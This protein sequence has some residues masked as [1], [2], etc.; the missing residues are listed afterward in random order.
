MAQAPSILF[1]ARLVL[2]KPTGIGQYIASLLPELI[3]QAPEWHFHLLRRAEPWPD[4]RLAQLEAPNLTHHPIELPHMALRQHLELPRLA[5]RLGVALLH[6]P[7]FDAPVLWQPV[8]V[9]VT[10]HDA[11]YLVHPKFFPRMSFVKRAY[12]R[13]CFA[14][15]LQR[16]AA[17]IVDS[18]STTADLTRLFG[19]PAQR[20]R[21]VYPAANPRFERVSEVVV[22]AL[23]QRYALGRPFIL[24]VGERR[25]HKNHVGLV[26]AYAASQ[27]R[28][29]HD[30][31]I[32]GQAYADYSEPEAVA[33]QLGVGTAVHFLS[34]V[35]DADLVAFYT[36][37]DLFVLVSL[38]E[39]F[40]LPIVEAM[41]CGTPVITAATTSAGE[42]AG[43]GGIR[44]DP[45][46]RTAI[47][48]AIDQV[49]QD[50][51][52][53]Q[54]WVQRGWVRSQAFSW[55]RA[56]EETLAVYRCVLEQQ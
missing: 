7:H 52:L 32:I 34:D 39:G 40:G 20:M 24:S 31:I 33:Q 47:A 8:P 4:Y 13:F 28:Q 14:Q 25:P 2:A 54:E 21:L 42:V 26:R 37:A 23:R 41:A 38:Y 48:A 19:T 5:R 16:A 18:A 49:L 36:A 50:R 53:H 10:L 1:D 12:M 3:R 55:Q 9:V 43:E 44:V 56:A 35:A 6:Y 46:D 51:T 17:V 30:L 45:Q 27:S 15:S 11:K 29:T 22:A